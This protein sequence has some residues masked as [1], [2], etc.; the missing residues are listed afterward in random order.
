GK[1]KHRYPRRPPRLERLFANARPFYF[2]TFNTYARLPLLARQEVHETFCSFC[3]R[4][5]EHAIAVGRYVL[6]PDH[7]HLFV[8]FPPDGPTLARWTNSRQMDQLSPD[9]STPYAR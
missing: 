3:L 9:G 8:A 6:M 7:V 5:Q 2:V 1:Q 4:A